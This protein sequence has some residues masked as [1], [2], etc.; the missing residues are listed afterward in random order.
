MAHPMRRK[1]RELTDGAEMDEILDKALVGHLGL[2]D[3]GEPYVLPM[4][5]AVLKGA[6]YL[7]CAREG[8]QGARGRMIFP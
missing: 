2:C 1:D 5:F 6:L 7:H 3:E 8:R 4:N